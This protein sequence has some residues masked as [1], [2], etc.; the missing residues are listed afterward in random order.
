MPKA[1]AR[2]L[3]LSRLYGQQLAD[4]IIATQ[5]ELGESPPLTPYVTREN[6]AARARA[7]AMR[8]EMLAGL[9]HRSFNVVYRYSRWPDPQGRCPPDE[10]LEQVAA[11]L[12][13]WQPAGEAPEATA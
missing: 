2:R 8:L 10:W 5:D 13:T 9:T 1:K 4:D 7:A 12:A 6:W 3:R 11:I